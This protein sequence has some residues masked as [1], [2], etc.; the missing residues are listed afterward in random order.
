MLAGGVLYG[1]QQHQL[2]TLPRAGHISSEWSVETRNHIY[3]ACA[4]NDPQLK[5]TE[6]TKAIDSLVNR[7]TNLRTKS[8]DWIAG[9]SDL[10]RQL[11]L[12]LLDVDK[13]VEALEAFN[14]AKTIPLG[15]PGLRAE[16]GAALYNMDKLTKQQ[17]VD[18]VAELPFP[19]QISSE[20]ELRM[21]GPLFIEASRVYLEQNETA[22]ALN[23]LLKFH[24]AVRTRDDP[25]CFKP[26]SGGYIAQ[27]FWKFGE[28]D[29]AKNWLL[30]S[31]KEAAKCGTL[32]CRET[33]DMLR[34]LLVKA[35][36]K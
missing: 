34:S 11:G 4:A 12:A 8:E 33:L 30:L 35:N 22:K 18:L 28:K 1:I 27:A 6:F 10:L 17:L 3:R 13:P 25:L 5:A 16:V 19:N 32:A 24:K 36:K 15:T 29:T 31:E 14:A 7:S 2:S 21:W 20:S 23:Q 26:T 9:Y